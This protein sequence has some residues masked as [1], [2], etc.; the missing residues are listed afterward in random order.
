VE[1]SSMG[2]GTAIGGGGAW[3]AKGPSTAFH[4]V[5]L[6]IACGDREDGSYRART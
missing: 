2:R 4:A 1:R 5:P 3:A 6:P